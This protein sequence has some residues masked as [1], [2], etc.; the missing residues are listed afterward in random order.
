MSHWVNQPTEPQAHFLYIWADL[1]RPSFIIPSAAG[2]TDGKAMVSIADEMI[3]RGKPAYEVNLLTHLCFIF[4]C[5][6]KC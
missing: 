2:Y 6:G 1:F 5:T 3:L 4:S